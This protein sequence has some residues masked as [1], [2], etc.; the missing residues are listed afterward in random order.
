MSATTTT[1][2]PRRA[3]IAFIFVTVCSTCSRL[4]MVIPVLP[5]A[6]R[7]F[8]GGNTAKAAGS[9]GVFGTAWALMQFVSMP[10]WARSRTASAAGR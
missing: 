2:P 5:Q 9:F 7:S 3:A 4:G 1:A 8:E 10:V 6:G